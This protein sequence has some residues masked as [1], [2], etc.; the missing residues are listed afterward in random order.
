MIIV[1]YDKD[2]DKLKIKRSEP[3]EVLKLKIVKK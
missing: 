3:K 1:S 2:F